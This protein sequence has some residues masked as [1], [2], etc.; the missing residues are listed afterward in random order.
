MKS[1]KKRSI[2]VSLW[3]LSNRVVILV[4]N[5]RHAF[6]I[7]RPMVRSAAVI[8]GVGSGKIDPTVT[9]LGGMILKKMLN[10]MCI[11]FLQFE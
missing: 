4:W 8:K 5:N 7:G 1:V 10:E 3:M 11:F 9:S 6:V 2:A